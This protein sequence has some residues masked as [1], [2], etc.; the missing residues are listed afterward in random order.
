M[1]FRI[2]TQTHTHGIHMCNFNYTVT[3]T[4][5]ISWVLNAT[6]LLQSYIVVQ[7]MRVLH[8]YRTF[9]HVWICT[10]FV[11]QLI[12]PEAPASNPLQTIV[13]HTQLT[14]SSSCRW[15]NPFQRHV[16]RIERKICT[17]RETTLF[18]LQKPSAPSHC[19]FRHTWHARWANT[20]P[21][22]HPQPSLSILDTNH[23]QCTKRQIWCKIT[24]LHNYYRAVNPL[25]IRSSA[26]SST[27]CILDDASVFCILYWWFYE[28]H[29]HMLPG[30]SL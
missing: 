26:I 12:A 4:I 8:R 13:P 11:S 14:P 17:C 2:N 22:S 21:P 10:S 27:I 9:T 7:D 30:T 18:F 1:H 15:Y 5:G 16:M 6:P 20:Q 19:I 25:K 3:L 24:L 28:K 23:P 29:F